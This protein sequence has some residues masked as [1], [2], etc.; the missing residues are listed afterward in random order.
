MGGQKQTALQ[1]SELSAILKTADQRLARGGLITLLV[2]SLASTGKLLR[3]GSWHQHQIGGNKMN[4]IGIAGL[5][6]AL[7]LFATI[8]CAD[9]EKVNS[10]AYWVIVEQNQQFPLSTG[11][12]VNAG[13]LVHANVINADGEHLSQWCE[14]D[15]VTDA[16]G[17][18]V[19]GAG[20]C[21][22][23]EEDGDMLWVWFRNDGPGQGSTWG[24][25]GGT[26]EYAGATGGGTSS[27]PTSTSPDGQ[28][29]VNTSTGSIT[30]K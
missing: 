11:S 12:T 16:D 29:W 22:L 9:T 1:S 2:R 27:E 10:T 8:A 15:Q 4:K 17:K 28:S 30:T 21:T 14:G 13:G 23:I 7:S 18:P 19:G 26:G 5:T 3:A 24:V 6:A 20:F 25:I